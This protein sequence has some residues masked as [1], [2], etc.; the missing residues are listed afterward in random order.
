[1]TSLLRHVMNFCINGYVLCTVMSNT[2]E[3]PAH[4]TKMRKRHYSTT[5]MQKTLCF[6]SYLLWIKIGFFH[7]YCILNY[8]QS[9]STSNKIKSCL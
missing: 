1:M 9:L 3:M 4:N 7:G 8:I 5:N 6:V 2:L